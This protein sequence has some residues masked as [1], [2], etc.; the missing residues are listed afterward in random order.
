MATNSE[1]ELLETLVRKFGE[2][3]ALNGGFEK[4]CLMIEHVQEKQDESSKKLDKVSEALYDPDK[5]LFTR[6]QKIEQKLDTNIEELEKKVEVVPDVKSEVDDLKK[7]QSSIESIAGKQLEE[8]VMLVKL[9]KNLANIY[10]ALALSAAGAF[11]SMMFNLFK[12]G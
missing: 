9:R 12:R 10:W 4:L 8:L 6:V 5:G 3:R 11:A 7:F 1:R 2:S